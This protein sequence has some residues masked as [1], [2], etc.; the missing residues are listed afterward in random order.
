MN[1]TVSNS[2]QPFPWDEGEVRCAQAQEHSIT[3]NIKGSLKSN[4]GDVK[5][6]GA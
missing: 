5:A 4:A 1:A 3:L 6:I 2:E